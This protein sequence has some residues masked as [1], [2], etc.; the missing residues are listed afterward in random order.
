MKIPKH[1]EDIQSFVK[2]TKIIPKN[3]EKHDFGSTLCGV[4]SDRLLLQSTGPG[5]TSPVASPKGW[6]WQLKFLTAAV[7]Q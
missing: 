3:Q 4:P 2:V 5:A 6:P 7:T 1:M